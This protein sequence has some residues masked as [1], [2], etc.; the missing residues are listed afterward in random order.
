MFRGK[1]LPFICLAAIVCPCFSDNNLTETA[2]SRRTA[3]QKRAL[4]TYN[5]S[6]YRMQLLA[7]WMSVLFKLMSAW[8][9]TTTRNIIENTQLEVDKGARNIPPFPE[10]PTVG[11]PG[12]DCS[13]KNL[14]VALR[15]YIHFQGQLLQLKSV[16]GKRMLKSGKA[17]FDDAT[18]SLQG[19]IGYLDILN[20]TAL[21]MVERLKHSS[22]DLM[23][24]G[25]VKFNKLLP[26]FKEQGNS[27]AFFTYFQDSKSK[28]LHQMQEVTKL[29]QNLNQTRSL[30]Q[31]ADF[32][33]NLGRSLDKIFGYAKVDQIS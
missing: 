11:P 5:T 20:K 4:D 24:Q 18:I 22:R 31:I 7:N 16:V 30:F 14:Q 13:L 2:V 26:D 29:S 32:F 17:K 19:K 9:I 6:C 28:V 3:I 27:L 12:S 23:P 21:E 10:R 25:D 15:T 1:L 33:Q 8:T